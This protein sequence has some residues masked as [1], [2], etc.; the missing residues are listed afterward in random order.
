MPRICKICT[1]PDRVEIE[2]RLVSATPLR[3][4][5][6]LFR[7]SEDSLQ[8]HMQNHLSKAIVKAHERRE[9][10]LGDNLLA[11]ANRVRAESWRL[12][13]LAEAGGDIR[14]AIGA[15][16]LAL[17]SNESLAGM[18]ERAASGSNEIVMRVVDI[19]APPEVCPHCGKSTILDRTDSS[20]D[21][22]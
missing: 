12:L 13:A 4:T 1:H 11:E 16:K 15:A 19:S 7:V 2:K 3:E 9:E 8:R 10:R 18:L 14:A 17:E 5:S 20:D 6:A 21:P 22:A